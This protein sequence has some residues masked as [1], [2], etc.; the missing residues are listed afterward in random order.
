MANL[1]GEALLQS[2]R[3]E[4]ALR[5][6]ERIPSAQGSATTYARCASALETLGRYADADAALSRALELSPGVG[7]FHA[8]RA[9]VRA[10]LGRCEEAIADYDVALRVNPADSASLKGR[11]VCRLRGGSLLSGM[12]DLIGSWR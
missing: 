8:Q 7:V 2:G 3:A 11:G 5:E 10:E 12:G 1:R 9:R 6:F 4:A